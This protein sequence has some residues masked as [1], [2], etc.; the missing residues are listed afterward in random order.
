MELRAYLKNFAVLKEARREY[1]GV[2]AIN[3]LD[4][5]YAFASV[6]VATVFMSKSL[7]FSD[8]AAGAV[9]TWLGIASSIFLF[10][11]GPVIDRHGVKKTLYGALIG[12]LLIRGTL[13]LSA[14]WTEMPYRKVFFVGCLV[15]GCLPGA[16]RSTVNHVGNRRFSTP[17]SQGAAFNVWYIVVNIGAVGAGLLI[18]FVHLTLKLD[19]AWII[20]F[21]LIDAVVALPISLFWI[22][23]D[24][25]HE[26]VVPRTVGLQAPSEPDAGAVPIAGRRWQ[27]VKEVVRH[28]AFLRM[29]SAVTLL[30]GVRAAFLYWTVLSPKYWY[31]TIGHSARVGL[32]TTIN[33]MVIIIGLLLLVPVINKFSTFKMLTFGALVSGLSFLPLSVPW[34]WVSDDVNHAY[35]AMS[36]V[37]MCVFAFGEMMFSPRLS[38]YIIAIAPH[39]QEGAYSSFAALPWFV[40]KTVAGFVS[41]LLLMRWCPE[42]MTIDG[43]SKPLHDVIASRTL[44][45]GN[46]PEMMWLLLG[47]FALAGP[48]VMICFRRWFTK[49]MHEN[50]DGS[51]Q[52]IS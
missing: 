6:T 3:L 44:S 4:C 47:A 19:F 35:Y 41:G 50:A 1:W 39:G 48:L 33:P 32:L 13:T 51:H 52:D 9:I 43:V 10:A 40:G 2:Q 23:D 7:G 21:G 36:A 30:T 38:H 46:S 37:S 26:V 16:L 42:R 29:M 20:T 8:I 15:L 31:R 17:K 12:A 18:D 11:A 25:S 24:S 34:Y 28:P 14:F 27:Y 22:K 49:G 5:I 45:Y